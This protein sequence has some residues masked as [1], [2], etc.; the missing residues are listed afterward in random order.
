MIKLCNLDTHIDNFIKWK[1]FQ[2]AKPE[3]KEPEIHVPASVNESIE[4]NLTEKGGTEDTPEDATVAGV[5]PDHDDLP[6]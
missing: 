6:F 4:N 3:E 5:V 1:K 2:T